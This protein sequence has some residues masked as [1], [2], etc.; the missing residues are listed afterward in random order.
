MNI[1]RNFLLS[2][3]I[4]TGFTATG[5]CSD[6]AGNHT[7]PECTDS[8]ENIADSATPALPASVAPLPG[9]SERYII[10][11]K[12]SMSLTMFEPD[13]DIVAHFPV[14]TGKNAGNK[15]A[16]GDMRTP[17]GTFSV[18]QIQDAS[19]WTH[20][21]GDGNGIIEGAYGAWFIRLRTPG[22]SGIGIHGTHDPSSVGTRASE[23]CIR[24]R[25]NDID[26]LAHLVTPGMPVI[27]LPGEADRA[28]DAR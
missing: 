12:E 11:D 8:L 23:G 1:V 24:L 10:I 21:F 14:A 17:E 3:A 15:R 27:I 2:A 16:R 6:S 28:A 18:Q 22:F 25:N 19:A 9:Q 5:A 7:A 26:S 20:D 13:G 4:V